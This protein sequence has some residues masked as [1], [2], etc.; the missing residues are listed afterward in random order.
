MGQLEKN[1]N[2]FGCLFGFV[3]L[4]QQLLYLSK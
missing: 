1:E 4:N 2:V 3:Q